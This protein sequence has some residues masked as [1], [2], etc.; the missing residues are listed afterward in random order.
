MDDP[1]SRVRDALG[2]LPVEAQVIQCDPELAD[3]AVFCKHYGYAVE[4]S[5]NTILVSAKTGRKRTVA[6]VLLA[7]SRLDVNHV[8]RKRLGSRRV[9]FA[10]ADTTRELTGMELGG[11]TPVALPED[12]L[13]SMTS[14]I[15]GPRVVVSEAAPAATA[16]SARRPETRPHRLAR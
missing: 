6:C 9:S 10:S 5:V 8:V 16:P 14:A 2:R 7:D 1:G 11:V 13:T 15:A 12:M 3:T 4:D